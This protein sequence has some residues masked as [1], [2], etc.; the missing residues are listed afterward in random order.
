MSDYD[1]DMEKE[2][3]DLGLTAPRITPEHIE[4][5]LEKVTYDVHIV[6][7]TTTTV[8]TAFDEDGFSLCVVTMACASP[9]NFNADLGAKYGIE[10]AKKVASDKLWEFEGYVLKKQLAFKPDTSANTLGGDKAVSGTF[11]SPE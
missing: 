11:C 9:E 10:K 3:Q 5:L 2:I 7:N 8:V 6:P 1:Q 4:A